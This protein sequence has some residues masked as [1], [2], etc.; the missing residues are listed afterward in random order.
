MKVLA[1]NIRGLGQARKQNGLHGVIRDFEAKVCGMF[2]T[3]C[4]GC[5]VIALVRRVAP[6]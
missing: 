2:E 5:D 4:G 6:G 3:K 1:W